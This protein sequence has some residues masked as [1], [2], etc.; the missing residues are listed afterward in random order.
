[1]RSEVRERRSSMGWPPWAEQATACTSTAEVACEVDRGA[2]E[3]ATSPDEIRLSVVWT[4]H[5]RFVLRRQLAVTV[6]QEG[7][8]WVAEVPALGMLGCGYGR[9][10]AIAEFMEDFAAVYDGLVRETDARLTENARHPR[11]AVTALVKHVDSAQL[12]SEQG[13]GPETDGPVAAVGGR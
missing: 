1:M 11:D 2:Q 13:A 8:L 6:R 3:I 9:D 5:A 7:G 12:A 10:V 4:G